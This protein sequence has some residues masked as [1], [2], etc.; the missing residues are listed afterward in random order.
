MQTKPLLILINGSTDGSIDPTDRGLAY[1]DGLFE[2]LRVEA[3]AIPLQSLHLQ[4]LELGCKRLGLDFPEHD[5]LADLD[6]IASVLTVHQRCIVKL[7]VTRG[8]GARGYAA[9]PGTPSTRLVIVYPWLTRP[10][11]HWDSGITAW[12]CETRLSSSPALAGIKH[13]NRL[14]YVLARQEWQNAGIIE[15]LLR[16]QRGDYVEA[17]SCNLFVVKDGH[18]YTPELEDCG[19]H[20]IVRQLII[21]QWHDAFAS[22]AFCSATPDFLANA[23]EVFLTNSLIGAW[24]VVKCGDMNWQPGPGCREIQKRWEE[25]FEC[26]W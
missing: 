15:G 3:G 10:R 21:Q 11:S 9:T 12:C 13:L 5:L 17:T 19:V 22:L 18:L 6:Q 16:D 2:T 20:G 4:R 1:G 23:D 24:P 8:A 25:I 26:P 14:E 7:L